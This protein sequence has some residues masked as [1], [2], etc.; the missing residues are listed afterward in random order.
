MPDPKRISPAEANTL[1][2]E[3]FTYLD[4][5]TEEEF[6]LGHPAGAHNVPFLV[7]GPEGRVANPDFV[8]VMQAA[9]PKDAKLVVGCQGGNRSLKAAHELMGA[10]YTNIV[11]QRAGWGG[12]KDP[13][14]AVEP[15]WS[16][17]GLPSETGK[18]AGRQ[19]ADIRAKKKED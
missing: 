14:G 9:F 17:A 19:Y 5:R 1:L 4:V 16:K 2:A 18:P 12:G 6:E 7:A 15:G 3:G 13:F 8:G 10:G 11:E